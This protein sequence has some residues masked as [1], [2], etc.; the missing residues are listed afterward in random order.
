MVSIATSRLLFLHPLVKKESEGE[1]EGEREERRGEKIK[2]ANQQ[3]LLSVF[4]V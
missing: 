3:S 2:Q 4:D 1:G